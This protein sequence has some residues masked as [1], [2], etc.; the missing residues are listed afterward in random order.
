MS[1]QKKIAEES[2]ICLTPKPSQSKISHVITISLW[3]LS[4]LDLSPLNCAILGGVLEN[5]TN[6]TFLPNIGSPKTTIEE[7]WN[8]MSDEYIFKAR[9]SLWR[10]VGTIIEKKLRP[11]LINLLFC[12][13]LPILLFI[14]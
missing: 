12:V 6:T 11:Y 9:K 13:Y 8:K 7:D 14:F 2:M 10:H 3:V 5:K 4:S 1:E